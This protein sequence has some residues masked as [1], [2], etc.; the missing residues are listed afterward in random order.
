MSLGFIFASSYFWSR[1]K[2]RHAIHHNNE[3]SLSTIHCC[4]YYHQIMFSG[5]SSR[6]FPQ[7]AS[8][9]P[10]SYP[11]L[12][13]SSS[14]SAITTTHFFSTFV[15]LQSRNTHLT[16]PFLLSLPSSYPSQYPRVF[17]HPW[18]WSCGDSSLLKTYNNHTRLTS[19]WDKVLFWVL[20]SRNI[21]C[22]R[23][24]KGILTHL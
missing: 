13:S 6:G 14:S 4:L 20:I 15:L 11:E 17:E 21:L 12:S 19:F 2:S 3:S 9:S 1:N 24:Q 8:L 10:P 7:L 18:S 22:M 16:A 5:S 23:P